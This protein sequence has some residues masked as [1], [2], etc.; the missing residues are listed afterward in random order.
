M[1]TQQLPDFSDLGDFQTDKLSPKARHC[2]LCGH[3]LKGHP[4]PRGKHC[5]QIPISEAQL[6]NQEIIRSEKNK[7]NN[8]ERKRSAEAKSRA[9]ERRQSEEA[10]RK[11]RDRKRSEE[12]K[13]KAKKRQHTDEIKTKDKKRK[14]ITKIG[15]ISKKAWTDPGTVN[16]VSALSLPSMNAICIDCGAKLFPWEL[17][18]SKENGKTFSKCCSYGTIQLNPF[19]DPSPKLKELFSNKDKQSRQF[20]SNIR[21][22]NGLVAMAS[23]G[24][25]AGKEEDYSGC[26]NRGPTPYK[27]S[28]QLYHRL[29][30]V[31]FPEGGEAPKF[32]QIYVYDLENELSNRVSYAKEKNYDDKID[33]NTLKLI[34]E[35]LKETN[36]YVKQF[37]SAADI[38]NANPEKDIKIVFKS[39]GSAGAKKK[40]RDPVVTDVCIIAP[41]DQT[42]KRDIVLYRNKSSHPDQKEIT[43]INQ[44]HAI[45]DPSCYPLILPS[46][47]DGFSY[48]AEFLKTNGKKISE[49]EFYRFHIQVREGSFN[50]L[51]KAKRLSQE[52]FCDQ[53]SKIEGNRLAYLKNHQDELR[54]EEYTGLQ[55]ALS[56]AQAAKTGSEAEKIGTRI[57]LPSSFT[58]SPRYMYKHYLDALAIAQKE[59]K[60]DLFITMTGNPKW[61]TVKENL[62]DGQNPADRPDVVNRVFQKMLTELVSDINCGC[63]GTMKARVHTVEGQFRCLKHAHLLLKLMESINPDDVDKVIQ[64]QLPDKELDPEL[65]EC[66][67]TFMLHGPC[68]TANPY[69]PC[70]ENGCCSKGYPKD[71]C[72]ETILPTEGGY[73]IYQRLNNGRTFTKGKFCYDNRWIVPFNGY[74]LKKFRCHIN[75]EFVGSF[76]SI[77]YIYKYIH[78]GVD[79][80]TIAL[81]S[82]EKGNENDEIG[83]YINART[84]DPYDAHWRMMEYPIQ[85]RFPAVM[86]LAIHLDGQQNVVFRDGHAEEALEKVRDTTL[87]AYFKLN[88][89]DADARKLK[90]REIPQYY[91]WNKTKGIWTRRKLFIAS[92]VPRMIGRISN[93]SPVQGERFYLRLLLNHKIGSFSY[94]DI[95]KHNGEEFSTFK[96]VCLAMG[97]LEDDSEWKYSMMEISNFGMPV[98]IRASFAVIL[99]YCRPTEPL[100]IF[101]QFLDIMSEDFIYQEKK[102]RCCEM[103]DLDIDKIKVKVLRA[104]DGELRNM[105]ASLS[106]FTDMPKPPPLTQEEK[107]AMMFR[108][109]LFDTAKQSLIV[110]KLQ[111]QLN[112]TQAALCEDLY[113]AVHASKD[114]HMNKQFIVNAPGGYG[115]TFVFQT[116]A[117]KIRSEGGI[118]L[119]VAS[120]GLAA[121]N[122]EGGRTAHS[123]FKIPID[124][125][126][127]SFCNIKA[128]SHLAKLIKS[129]DLIIWD[130]IFSV[131]RHNIE[132]VE[133]TLKDLTS[134]T[135]PWG[136]KV[137]CLGGDPRQTLPIVRRG[138][139]AQ[140]VR[141]CIQSSLLYPGMKQYKLNQNMRTDK[142]EV[143]FASY[144]LSVG[145]GKEEVYEEE[146]PNA[147]KIP[148]DYLVSE[149]DEL[150]KIVFPN[151]KFGCYN[152]DNLI[153]GTIYT[154]LNKDMKDINASCIMEF[155]G[156]EKE[157]LSADSILEDDHRDAIPVE[158]LNELTP[159]GLPDHKLFLKKGCPVMLLRNLQAGPNCSLRNGTRMIVMQMMERAVECEVASGRD[160]GMRVFLPRIPHYDRSHDFPFTVVRRQFP[161]KLC[162]CVSVNK[163]QGQSSERV[164]VYLPDSVFAHGQL[165]TALSRGKRR[166]DVQV[167]IGKNKL[168]YTDNIVYKELL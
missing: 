107:N 93:V 157:Y 152:S 14:R 13:T 143:D 145:E 28:G 82:G 42:Q 20:L 49:L 45:Y 56:K 67:T 22:Y 99:Q 140:I 8:R 72:D 66:V 138:G 102:A 46:G 17:S 164:G 53:W 19:T 118:V 52:F 36:K 148:E 40:H 2:K 101:E 9:K 60:F 10:K 98:Q 129:A 104:I 144:L 120:T 91:V 44:F 7:A 41:G 165:Y 79:V 116:I 106:D 55:D 135:E 119:C 96:E 69:A 81:K 142:D 127:D 131:H 77:R 26:K 70:M 97:L 147:I 25:H 87:T 110:S 160:K 111:P 84:I 153:A 73:P 90:Y 34:Q 62:F 27:I 54:A 137:V 154:P 30:S 130:E 1:E 134:S 4:L 61:D 83:K 89:S 68:G 86:N 123:R 37:K 6:H 29:P 3:P 136:G 155:P 78:K 133:R 16:P 159:S 168:G 156:E 100:K 12:A 76:L 50:T 65:F 58:G 15:R 108:D 141:A 85:D 33:M 114:E 63:F 162:F 64:A 103:K 149:K 94:K 117:A 124:I 166:R 132:A 109:E 151:L 112:E 139:R 23:K 32:A 88:Q 80:S 35:E 59:G 21:R 161:L 163:G 167:F 38:F 24:I 150:I 71:F 5:Q 92:K 146:S 122:L 121:Q 48:D 75:V 115:K 11:D 105:G 43:S 125:L 158:F 74:L 95:L 128:Q 113:Q 18:K 47:D 57:V 39:K 51:H 126:D 31:L